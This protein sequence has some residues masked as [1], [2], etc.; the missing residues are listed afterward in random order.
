MMSGE[1]IKYMIT[2]SVEGE[3]HE[4]DVGTAHQTGSSVRGTGLA[5]C[6]RVEAVFLTRELASLSLPLF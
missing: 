4:G 5:R 1:T 6:D 3:Q 2:R